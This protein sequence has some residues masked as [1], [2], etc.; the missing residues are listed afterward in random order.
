M[1]RKV[2]FIIRNLDDGSGELVGPFSVGKSGHCA[3]RVLG[4]K[5]DDEGEILEIK[6]IKG[7][8]QVTRHG[9]KRWRDSGSRR[10][11]G[12]PRLPILIQVRRIQMINSGALIH[13]LGRL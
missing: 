5:S 7:W 2:E 3:F 13:A 9:K 10:L 1:C 8:F 6:G 12:L 4:D 11:P